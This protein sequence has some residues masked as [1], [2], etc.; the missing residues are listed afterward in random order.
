MSTRWGQP[1]EGY[2]VLRA[3]RRNSTYE[4]RFFKYND[5]NARAL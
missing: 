1:R 3:F 4:S 2:S 5:D